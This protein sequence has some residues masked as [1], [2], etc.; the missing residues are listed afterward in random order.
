[1]KG[2]FCV[3]Q[4]TKFYLFEVKFP[5]ELSINV[6]SHKYFSGRGEPIL[7]KEISFLGF[8][9]LYRHLSHLKQIENPDFTRYELGY[10]TPFFGTHCEKIGSFRD[11]IF[12]NFIVQ[13][14]QDWNRKLSSD[15]RNHSQSFQF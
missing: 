11:I 2:D 15:H 14:S 9:P 13:L 4:S 5:Q 10:Q 6:V 8:D 1:M 7:L 3:A 12:H